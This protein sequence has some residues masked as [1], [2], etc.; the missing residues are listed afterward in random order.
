MDS[1]TKRRDLIAH[2]YTIADKV[3]SLKGKRVL[4]V[5]KGFEKLFLDTDNRDTFYRYGH[6]WDQDIL[7][8]SIASGELSKLY[9]KMHKHLVIVTTIGF[10]YG[11]EVYRE[12]LKALY[13][14]D[15]E[16]D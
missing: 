11:Q 8:Y 6:D 10:S 14:Q 3:R 13:F 12:A 15:T 1:P 5:A 7:A 16:L 9:M 4:I 2:L